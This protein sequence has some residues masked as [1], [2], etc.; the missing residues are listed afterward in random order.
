MVLK[1]DYFPKKPLRYF[2][3]DKTARHTEFHSLSHSWPHN[4]HR[5]G[6]WRNLVCAAYFCRNWF[7][8]ASAQNE[9]VVKKSS[10]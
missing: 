1:I 2:D 8:H 3:E 6:D 4:F 5:N 9:C 7:R 10:L